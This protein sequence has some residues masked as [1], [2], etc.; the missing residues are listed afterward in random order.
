MIKDYKLNYKKMLDIKNVNSSTLRQKNLLFLNEELNSIQA[1][2]DT[3][4]DT[5]YASQVEF[6][7][8]IR[9]YDPVH[10]KDMLFS[11]QEVQ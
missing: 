10:K 6:E 5:R 8:R 2:I 7:L 4:V 3:K 1:L 11:L 9:P